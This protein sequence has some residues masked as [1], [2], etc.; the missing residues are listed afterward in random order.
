[1]GELA[2]LYSIATAAFVGGSLVPIGGHNMLEPAALGVPVLFGPHTE[3]FTEP[4]AELVRAGG[5][6]VVHDRDSMARA[7]CRLLDQPEG[8]TAMGE[9]AHQVVA[10]N[11]GAL[12]RSIDLIL[13]SLRMVLE[14]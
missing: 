8:A 6:E 1:M 14:R 13:A 2:G 11:R 12:S 3:H 4:A 9:A 7:I 5:A 10:A